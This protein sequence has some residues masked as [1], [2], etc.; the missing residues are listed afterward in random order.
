MVWVTGGLVSQIILT[1]HTRTLSG[2]VCP[3][4]Y[5]QS[6]WGESRLQESEVN[7]KVFMGDGRRVSGP[8][9]LGA[10]RWA[11][12]DGSPQG[13]PVSPLSR[14]NYQTHSPDDQTPTTD[15]LTNC[16]PVLNIS[17]QINWIRNIPRFP[18]EF[19]ILLLLS[20]TQRSWGV[21]RCEIHRFT[22]GYKRI[23]ERRD[24]L[25]SW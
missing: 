8:R 9:G 20:I 5:S 14:D 13:T 6:I 21:V 15:Q 25:L 4:G 19:P 10:G 18:K 24:I 12:P 3:P 23:R 11:G 22:P 16:S 7:K 1:S 2:L 17:C